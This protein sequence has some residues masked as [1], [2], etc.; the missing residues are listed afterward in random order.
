MD[1]RLAP[2][3]LVAEDADARRPEHQEAPLRG[4]KAEPSRREHPQ[5]MAAGKHDR[6]GFGRAQAGDDPVRAGANVGGLLA[7][8][9]AVVEQEPAGALGQ[10]L[11]G[12]AAFVVAVAPFNKIRIDLGGVAEP[13]EVAGAPRALERAREDPV[14]RLALEALPQAPRLALA[15]LAER[16]I[17]AAGVPAA[18]APFRFAMAD[19]G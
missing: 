19:E 13:G 17:G 11:A 18:C 7:V 3:V 4:R 5:D 2:A 9:A 8:R 14:E 10:D 15:F 1:R 6:G 12:L 16:N